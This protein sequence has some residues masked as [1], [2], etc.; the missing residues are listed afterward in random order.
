M[1]I[2]TFK[3]KVENYKRASIKIISRSKEDAEKKA[4]ENLE[5]YF[6]EENIELKLVDECPCW[7]GVMLSLHIE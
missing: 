1:N 4:L 5:A 6:P 7:S 2:Y 3:F